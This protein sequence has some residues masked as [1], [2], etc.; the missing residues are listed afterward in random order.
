MC[1]GRGPEGSSEPPEP[2]MCFS[3]LSSQ[4]EYKNIHVPTHI[5]FV[6]HIGRIVQEARQAL[7]IPHIRGMDVHS[8]RLR[9]FK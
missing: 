8:K 4:Y 5:G 3:L 6:Y 9:G 2:R 7:R 1:I